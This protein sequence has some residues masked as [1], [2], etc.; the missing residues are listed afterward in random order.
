MAAER[1]EVITLSSDSEQGRWPAEGRPLCRNVPGAPLPLVR[2]AR[3]FLLSPLNENLFSFRFPARRHISGLPT[4][5]N[6]RTPTT[7]RSLEVNR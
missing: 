4:A 6:Q 7:V 2:D 3:Y 5:G 1:R